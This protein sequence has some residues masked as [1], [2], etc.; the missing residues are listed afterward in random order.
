MRKVTRILAQSWCWVFWL[1]LFTSLRTRYPR[2]QTPTAVPT[3]ALTPT[4]VNSEYLQ[5]FEVVWSTVNETYFDPEFRWAGLGCGA[6][7]I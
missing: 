3:L 2:K 5:V 6:C 7:R 1:A 4:V